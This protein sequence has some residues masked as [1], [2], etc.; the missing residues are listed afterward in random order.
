[1][2]YKAVV[3]GLRCESE[4]PAPVYKITDATHHSVPPAS[5]VMLLHCLIFDPSGQFLYIRMPI[6]E[7]AGLLRK[8]LALESILYTRVESPR[9]WLADEIW[10]QYIDKPGILR[11]SVSKELCCGQCAMRSPLLML[12][13]ALVLLVEIADLVAGSAIRSDCTCR[14]DWTS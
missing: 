5:C 10:H 12:R 11:S 6:L 7:R 14:A 8:T 4:I 13:K 1:V 3:D 9:R 2:A